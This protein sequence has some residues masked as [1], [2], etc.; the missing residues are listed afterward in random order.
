VF[1]GEREIARMDAIVAAVERVVALPAY[2][3]HAMR[4]APE[5]AR[6]VPRAAGVFLGYDFH[7]GAQG[8]QLIEVNT[9]AGGGLLN[10]V[11]ARASRPAANRWRP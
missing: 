9:N 4:Y 8:P 3:E 1:V 10:A 5:A 11:L 6:H 2:V 7:L